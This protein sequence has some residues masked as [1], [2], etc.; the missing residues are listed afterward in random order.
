VATV[1]AAGAVL[2]VAAGNAIITVTETTSGKQAT[3]SVTVTGEDLANTTW[4]GYAV[5][6]YFPYPIS[7]VQITLVFGPL[8][9][10]AIS[11]T[12]YS[13][14]AGLGCLYEVFPS[15]TVNGSD[16]VLSCPCWEPTAGGGLVYDP[17]S[18]DVMNLTV[19]GT[20]MSGTWDIYTVQ[21]TKQ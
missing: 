9:D 5:W 15:A 7:T 4:V 1:S 18:D 2:G 20:N 11:A 6:N 21:L 12:L 8:Q 10:G 14:C 16:V 13:G 19:S 17:T 3:A